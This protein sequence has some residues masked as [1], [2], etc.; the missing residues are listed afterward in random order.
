M[1]PYVTESETG[2]T[3]PLLQT[4][5]KR[6]SWNLKEHIFKCHNFARH[7][8]LD[9]RRNDGTTMAAILKVCFYY[10]ITSACSKT[11]YHMICGD[12][13]QFSFVRISTIEYGQFLF[14]AI[15]A[16]DFKSWIYFYSTDIMIGRLSK[17]ADICFVA[18]IIPVR[19][20]RIRNIN[21]I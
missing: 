21:Q 6:R 1:K 19:Y 11:G 9:V 13:I 17:E 2:L 4:H 12:N 18:Y 7:V 20:L 3:I 5:A 16:F 15:T 10:G 8:H 14:A